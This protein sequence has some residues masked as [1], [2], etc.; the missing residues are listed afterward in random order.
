MFSRYLRGAPARD[1]PRDARNT[2][3]RSANQERDESGYDLLLYSTMRG[4]GRGYPEP[5]AQGASG[6]G[7][8]SPYDAGARETSYAST[9]FE[10]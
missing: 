10:P 9:P 1:P 7:Y 3:Q 5:P 8:Q 6:S 4:D 2:S